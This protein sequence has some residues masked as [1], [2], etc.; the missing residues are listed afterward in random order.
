MNEREDWLL[1]QLRVLKLHFGIANAVFGRGPIPPPDHEYIIVAIIDHS[2]N[3]GPLVFVRS[4]KQFHSGGK[5]IEAEE[6]LHY[7]L[8]LLLQISKSGADKDLIAFIHCADAA[9][10]MKNLCTL[11]KVVYL[12]NPAGQ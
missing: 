1:G 2:L 4:R 9:R 5:M 7:G 12:R 10:V 6:C 3:K 11:L 8:A